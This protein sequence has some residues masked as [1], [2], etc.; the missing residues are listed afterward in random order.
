M[1]SLE[2]KLVD[3]MQIQSGLSPQTI[4]FGT[5]GVLDPFLQTMKN[6]NSTSLNGQPL[7]KDIE[8]I[9]KIPVVRRTFKCHSRMLLSGIQASVSPSLIQRGG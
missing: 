4:G 2:K 3:E 7:K 9:L 1:G 5:P 6:C 8:D